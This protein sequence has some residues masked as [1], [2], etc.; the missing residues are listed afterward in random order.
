MSLEGSVKKTFSKSGQQISFSPHIRYG[1]SNT[2]LNAWAD[3]NLNKRSF[4][5]NDDGGSN[6][7]QSWALS[8]GKRITQFNKDN[9]ISETLNGLY[10]LLFRENYMKIYENYFTELNYSRR[11]DNGFRFKINGLYEDRLPINNTTDYSFFGSHNKKFTPN[12]PF[13]K[14]DSQFVRHQAFITSI[15]VQFRPGLRYS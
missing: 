9:P 2:H 8:G 6:N 15:D 14:L 4:S 1:F 11:F 5:F 10:T 13:E 7:R 12:Y 3:I